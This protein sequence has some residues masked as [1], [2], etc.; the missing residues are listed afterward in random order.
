L[1]LAAPVRDY[2]DSLVHPAARRDPLTAA[3]HRAFIAPRLLGGLLALAMLPIVW[4]LRGPPSP[5]E[6]AALGWLILPILVACYL[7][8]TGEFDQAHV[9]SALALAILVTAVAAATGG[10]ASFAASWLVLVPL[11]AALADS[12]RGAI[13]AALFAFASAALLLMV[14]TGF[15]PERAHESEDSRLLATLGIGAGAV[16]AG[17]LALGAQAIAQ[18]SKRTR[19]AEEA[20]FRLLVRNM[21]DVVIRH[22]RDGGVLFISPGAET[23]FGASARELH[24]HGLFERIHVAD[25]P[26]YLT[27]IA[28]AATVRGTRSIELRVRRG[29]SAPE[30]HREARFIWIEMRCRPLAHK[31]GE[32]PFE[33]GDRQ[34]VSV[35]RDVTERKLQEQALQHARGEFRRAGPPTRMQFSNIR[36]KKSA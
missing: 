8:R 25:R 23:L 14:P 1:G 27:A 6:D 34:L 7:S 22:G 10:I 18:I 15:A 24:G 32:M 16:Y 28:D 3:R 29:G 33:G 2:I 13:A 21:T 9:L 19:D 5:L 31:A 30:Q 26:A 4:V 17:V 36:M 11:D 35:M 12:R 20:H